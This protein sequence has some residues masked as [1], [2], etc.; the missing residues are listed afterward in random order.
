MRIVSLA[1][2]ALTAAPALAQ[3]PCAPS[4]DEMAKILEGGKYNE[5]PV[6][7][8][9]AAGGQYRFELWANAVTGTW[10]ATMQ[11]P[12][13]RTCIVAAGDGFAPAAA[14]PAGQGL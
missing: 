12:N 4:R 8:G 5:R 2:L 10:T 9:M 14:P 13:G 11:Q 7:T 6:I 1:V 3:Q